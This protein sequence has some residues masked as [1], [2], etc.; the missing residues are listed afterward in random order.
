MRTLMDIF[1]HRKVPALWRNGSAPDSRSG[2]CV[3]ESRRGH[4]CFCTAATE[5]GSSM[6]YCSFVATILST[7]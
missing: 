5:T 2:G 3:F 6:T 1:Q 7:G 4:P